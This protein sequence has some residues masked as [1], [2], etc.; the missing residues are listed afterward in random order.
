MTGCIQSTTNV[1]GIVTETERATIPVSDRSFLYGDS[2]YEVIR[3]YF[4]VP[5]FFDEHWDRLRNSAALINLLAGDSNR[6]IND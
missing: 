3:T 2:V 4:G 6:V 5:L 1:D